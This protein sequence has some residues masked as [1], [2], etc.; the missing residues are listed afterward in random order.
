MNI[1]DSEYRAIGQFEVELSGGVPC[2]SDPAFRKFRVAFDHIECLW[3]ATE[4]M[5]QESHYGYTPQSALE[6]LV[7]KLSRNS[8]H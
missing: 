3:T 7:E 6:S 5:S 1:V 4:E 8:L 2:T